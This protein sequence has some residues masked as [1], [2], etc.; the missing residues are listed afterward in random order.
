MGYL[1]GIA[2]VVI[3]S[4]LPKLFGIPAA[5]GSLAESLA[6]TARQL[7][8]GAA[9]PL[10]LLFGVGTIAVILGCRALPWRL[11]GVLLAVLASMAVAAA[12]GP[13]VRRAGGG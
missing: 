6:A 11:P 12:A 4:Q 5:G 7:A 9:Q 13:R 3:A 1:N 10:A 8:Q 2:L